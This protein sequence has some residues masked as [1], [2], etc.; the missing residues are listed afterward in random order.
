[1]K[2]SDRDNSDD[3]Y[4]SILNSISESVY[5]QDEQ[6]RFLFI[7]KAALEMY[8]Y[9]EETFLHK[10]P[11]FLAAPD[12]NDMTKIRDHIHQA[13]EGKP[14]KFEFWGKR[15]D[16]ELFLKEVSLTSGL[17]FGQKAVLA[18][19]RDIS[20]K[21]RLIN[22]K[23]NII[24]ELE[25]SE[26][27]YRQVSNMLRL[28]CD[29]VPDMIWA[30]DMN[31]RF[32]FTN[33]AICNNLLNAKDTDEPIGKNDLFFAERER[34][35]KPESPDWHTFGEICR[36]SDQ[37]V[38]DSKKAQ[39]FDEFGNVKGKFLFLDVF[40]APFVD[41]KGTMIGTVGCGRDVTAERR[42]QE[43]HAQ[44]EKQ[45][46]EKTARMNALINAMPDML[47]VVDKEG[48]FTDYHAPENCV[49]L[50]PEDQIIGSKITDIFEESEAQRHLVYYN[51]CRETGKSQTFRYAL[52]LEGNDYHFEAR[53]SEIDDTHIL[54][55]VRDITNT[56]NMEKEISWQT[57][58]QNI[59]MGL[60][61]R[62][63][64]IP[65][66]EIDQAV[67]AAIAQMGTFTASDR[68]YIFDYD[69]K[70]E[71]MINTFEWCSEG[72]SPEIE[73]L[74]EVPNALVP[75]WVNAHL[76]AKPTL[77]PRVRDLPPG[78]NL[79]QILEPQGIQ[80][81]ITIPLMHEGN[82]LGYIGFDAVKQ[83]KKWNENELA[84]LKLF[85]QLLTNLK[86]K[87]RIE[88]ELIV[89]REKAEKSDMLKTAFMNNISHEVRTP[90]NS[91]I[92]FSDLVLHHDITE[93]E[94]LS[95]ADL[96]KQ[97]SY[98]LIQTI[99]DYM[100]S[101]VI[102]SGNQEVKKTSIHPF[103]LLKDLYDQYIR[104][105]EEKN[106]KVN[107]MVSDDYRDISLETDPELLRKILNHLLS[108]AVK[109]TLKG[110]IVAGFYP[111]N[112]RL[113]FYIKDTGVGISDVAAPFIFDFFNQEDQSS[114]RLF[115]GSGL[116]LS[117]A[118]GLVR[119]LKGDIW[120][121]TEKGKGSTFYFSIPAINVLQTQ[122]QI[123]K[124]ED[125]ATIKNERIILLV[126]DEVYNYKF[127]RALLTLNNYAEVILATNGKDAVEQCRQNPTIN[128]VLMDLKLPVMSGFEAT[129]HIKTMRKN[130]PV[131]AITAFAMSGD[132]SKA[133]EAGCDD[134]I[135]KPVSKDVLFSKIE[136]LGL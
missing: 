112:D 24:K 130:L 25:A 109:F 128:L 118:K 47:F 28:M 70:K 8:G 55:T 75:E 2:N 123:K 106:V 69:F 93:E 11:E 16:G 23:E 85:A 105:A 74:Q 96:L 62:F 39:R 91:I 33:K 54:A 4:F 110:E 82:C 77:V 111:E 68:V 58:L 83:E 35:Y 73:N 95:Y 51:R 32:L 84:L 99:T 98:R 66:N 129:R 30:K 44:T 15:K 42:L 135:A 41:E 113:I 78:S 72:T 133:L 124:Q 136:K 102:V 17:F 63:I 50:M 7:N 20:E 45:L 12:R 60:A 94:K 34:N 52:N 19:S 64:N 27:N 57:E 9:D 40:K 87:A 48:F 67:N 134:Y 36:D 59:L 107:I 43:I 13:F 10:T 115:E 14:C 86:I 6:G 92:G 53:L 46:K 126:E 131:I 117:I 5:V 120:F 3:V 37:I 122:E 104:Q 119:L 29:N 49:L 81:L 101:S 103:Y 80:S 76:Q 89:A 114:V 31:K 88:G 21:K 65:Y 90:L 1:M 71:I 22:E 97:S 100:D 125:K 38:M 79:R 116:G 26:K 18:V 108:N 61:T 127:M 56:I 121:E 132:E